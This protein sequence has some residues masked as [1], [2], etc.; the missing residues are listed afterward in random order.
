MTDGL[1]V[2]APIVG[3]SGVVGPGTIVSDQPEYAED[4]AALV[5]LTLNLYDWAFVSPVI[6]TPVVPVGIPDVIGCSTAVPGSVR[7][8]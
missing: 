7:I 1:A 4:P 6:C 5:A 2:A 3:G 8:V